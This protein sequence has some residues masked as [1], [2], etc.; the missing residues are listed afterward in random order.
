[1]AKR[2]TLVRTADPRDVF[3]NV[4]FD[5]AYERQFVAL[6]AAIAHGKLA[7]RFTGRRC[8]FFRGAGKRSLGIAT[9]VHNRTSGLR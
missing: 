3:L 6:V 9:D 8:W 5:K 2:R 7:P 4:P 1:M